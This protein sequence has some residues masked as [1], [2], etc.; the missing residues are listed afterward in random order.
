[1]PY[2]ERELVADV[3]TGNDPREI[4]IDGKLHAVRGKEHVAGCNALGS[5]VRVF[6]NGAHIQPGR[7][8]VFFHCGLRDLADGDAERRAAADLTG[9]KQTFRDRLDGPRRNGE[10]HALNGHRA[11]IPAAHF[12]VGNADDLPVNVDERA[13]GVPLVDRRGGLE[14]AVGDAVVGDVAVDAGNDALGHRA[15]KFLAERISD[16]I[17]GVADEQRIGR[18]ERRSGETVCGDFQNSD[19]GT[20]IVADKKSVILRIVPERNARAAGSLHNVRVCKD[21][22]VLGKN[23]TGTPV[24]AVVRRFI[25]ERGDGDDR[26]RAVLINLLRGE[27]RFPGGG[28]RERY[29]LCGLHRWDRALFCFLIRGKIVFKK[30]FVITRQLVGRTGG[31][32]VRARAAA[33]E[34]T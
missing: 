27:R 10:R 30:R 4:L 32:R 2:G 3:E 20:R 15:A 33:E 6:G 5:A 13:A 11:D 29:A 17:Y 21:I 18:G 7:Q 26:G 24:V 28:K 1:M 34:Q 12:H 8:I 23:D 31:C 14:Q 16:G 19:V 22:S 25:R 9:F